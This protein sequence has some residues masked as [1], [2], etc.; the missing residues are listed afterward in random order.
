MNYLEDPIFKDA[1][2]YVLKTNNGNRNP[3]HNNEHTLFVFNVCMKLFDIYKKEYKLKSRDRYALGLAAIFH[4]YNHSGGKLKDSD[5]I[6]L[7]LEGI[8]QYTQANDMDTFAHGEDPYDEEDWSDEFEYPE[9]RIPGLSMIAMEY[10]RIENLIKCTEYPH[11]YKEN[12]D[13]LEMIIMDADTTI[14][15]NIS[16]YVMGLASELNRNL[17]EFVDYE[18]DYIDNIKYLLPYSNEMI[19]KRR[20]ILKK[21]LLKFKSDLTSK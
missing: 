2:N 21:D 16:K 15:D 13:I 12:L 10:K 4:D 18:F 20:E 1:Y 14:P 9:D 8:Y 19:D 6:K 3:Y 5:N 7:A 11:E 17:L